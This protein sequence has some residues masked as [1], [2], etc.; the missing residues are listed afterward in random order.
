MDAAHAQLTRQLEHWYGY[1]GTITPPVILRNVM[2]NPGWYTP[3]TPYQAEI[4]QGRL[5][6]LL[7]FQTVRSAA[8]RLHPDARVLFYWLLLFTWFIGAFFSILLTSRQAVADLTGLEFANASL[9]DEATAAAEAM[10]L[11][12]DASR[13]KKSKFLV[14][15]DVYPQVC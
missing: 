3:Y 11:C 9:L 1:F 12:F 6:M 5:E 7:N 4:S 2:E 10:F 8:T 13:K 14:S 15:S